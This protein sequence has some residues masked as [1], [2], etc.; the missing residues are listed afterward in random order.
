MQHAAIDSKST[1]PIFAGISFPS[2]SFSSNP[3]NQ[4]KAISLR[5][6]AS[7]LGFGASRNCLCIASGHRSL[8]FGVTV[9]SVVCSPFYRGLD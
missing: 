9:Y 7:G 3:F 1:A 6:R 4:Y 5:R 2:V 8:E